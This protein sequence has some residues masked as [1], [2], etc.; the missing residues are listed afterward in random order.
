MFVLSQRGRQLVDSPPL[1][2]YIAEHFE[3]VDISWD[4]D[5]RPDGYIALSIA[6]NKRMNDLLVRCLDRYRDVPSDVLGYGDA[7]GNLEF[8]KALADF[9]SRSF[10]GFDIDADRIAVLAGVGSVLEILFYVIADSGEGVLVPTPSYAGF[11]AD[12]ETR[13]GLS[14]VPI[15]CSSR[16]DFRLTPAMLDEAMTNTNVVVRALL[17]TTP[18]NPLGRVYARQDVQEILEWAE[19]KGIHVVF[20]EIYAL[21]VFGDQ[22]FVSAASLRQ[23]LG[24]RVHIVWG[25]SKDFGASGLRCGVLISG[26]DDVLR[27]VGELAY[28]ATCS[29]H[30]QY[31]L[32]R[33]VSD[34]E[35]VDDYIAR[36]RTDLGQAY[37]RVTE[38][39]DARGIV[40]VP[41]EAGF[42]LMCDLRAYLDAPTWNAER[43]LWR[44]ILDEANVNL[45]PG[46]ACRLAEPG[47]FRLCYAAESEEAVR[48]AIHRLGRVLGGGA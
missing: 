20:D 23:T 36:M 12:I 30:T 21:S 37:K 1:A 38:C 42:F 32:S 28:W 5:L 22:P 39:L 34:R 15:D 40:Y 35:I 19:G 14:I 13:N 3:R 11:W 29:R 9:M 8:R 33:L 46:E 18:D 47:F 2:G 6:E 26:D 17:F 43:C 25:F 31:L 10:L 44:R 45:T 4:A 7:V 16:D 27:G 24:E 41:A 48:V